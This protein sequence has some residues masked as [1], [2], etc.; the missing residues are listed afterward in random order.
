MGIKGLNALIN[1]HSPKAFRNGE[2]KTFF[3]RKVA[4]DASMC[5]YQFL[6][7]VRQQDGQQ[8]ANEEG[9][10]TSHLMGFFYRTIRMVGYGIKPC[11]V[12]DG[13]PPVLKGG[14]LE[15]RLKRREEAE[16]Q[17]LDM[18][19]T[20]TLAD[21]AK[22]ERRTVRVTREQ[23]DQAKK[24]LELMG[25]PYV[26]APCEAEAQCAE[27]A[28]GGKVYAAASE[29]MD[30]LCYE[31]PYLLR[32]MTTAEARKLPVTEIDYAK[33]M[34][35]LEMELPQFIDLCILLGCDYCETI[36]GVGP[37]TAFKLI[38]EHGS[39]EK[40]VE[41]IEN[42]PKSKQ[43]IP[44]NWPYN[45]ARELFLHPEVIPAS[46]CELEWKEPDEEA[47]VD[48]MVRQHGFSEQR[49]RDGASK[50]RKSLKTGTQGRLDKF[51]VVKK[52]PA[53]EKKGKNTK[54][55]KPKKKRK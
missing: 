23:N 15:K 42:N 37:V 13:K 39:I 46:E 30:T 3:G 36:K 17:R 6:I 29:D 55:E 31:T 16:K 18:K 41:A 43:K 24:L 9:E 32:H 27:L 45:E 54:E 51:F 48:Y 26:D 53:E 22:F 12:F 5:L 25:I 20:G 8:L 19:E 33:V 50:L 2:M 14:E 49:I 35:G 10:T 47:L 34:E 21:I 1:E 40:V 52:R 4:I 7:A 44:E 11:Y 38:K 28:K